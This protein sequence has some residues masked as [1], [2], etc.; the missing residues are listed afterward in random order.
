MYIISVIFIHSAQI[1]LENALFYQQNTRL[2]NLLF[3]SKFWQQNLS[4]P[5]Y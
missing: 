2:K 4:K 1:L 5:N 3:C